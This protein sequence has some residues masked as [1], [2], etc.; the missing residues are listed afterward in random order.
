MGLKYPQSSNAALSGAAARAQSEEGGEAKLNEWN[1]E[2]VDACGKSLPS[3]VLSRSTRAGAQPG[4]ARF[5][6]TQ[7]RQPVSNAP[8]SPKK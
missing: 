3:V 1:Q 4:V 6:F 2:N 8:D 5:K 7:L